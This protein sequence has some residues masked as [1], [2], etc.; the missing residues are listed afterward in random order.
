MR[1]PHAENA[2]IP[3]EKLAGYALDPNHKD[4]RHKARVFKASLGFMRGDSETVSLLIKNLVSFFDARQ[5]G[6]DDWGTRYQV[7]IPLT[8]RSGKATVRTG[9]MIPVDS[10]TPSLTTVFVLQDDNAK[11]Q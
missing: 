7:D 5:R 10:N 4:G 2:Q 9:W 1:L 8:G 6:T 11:A 3:L